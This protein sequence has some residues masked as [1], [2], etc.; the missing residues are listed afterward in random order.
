MKYNI[1]KKLAKNRYDNPL[2]KLKNVTKYDY[3]FLYELLKK[4]D[5]RANISH[6]KMPTYKKHVEF[7]KSKPYS[8]WQIIYYKNQ[9]A[10]SIYLTRQ[11]EVGIF[12]KKTL[13][14]KNIGKEAL[15]MLMEN[16]SRIRYLA[17]VAPKNT[18]SIRFFKKNGFKLIQYTFEI[19]TNLS[20]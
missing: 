4:R 1:Q 3:R 8:K 2:V 9:K 19:E 15:Q 13:Q 12:I 17:N 14:G 20:N 16:N 5:P 7:V 11:N 10:G 6:K 18:K